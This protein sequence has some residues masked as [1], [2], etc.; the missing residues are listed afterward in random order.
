MKVIDNERENQTFAEPRWL[1]N[2]ETKR[3]MPVV[4]M[5]TLNQ[6]LN[7]TM[8]Y[9][10]ADGRRKVEPIYREATPEEVA[11]HKKQAEKDIASRN[12]QCAEDRIRNAGVVINAADLAK[13]EAP[14]GK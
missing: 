10:Y 11:A 14:K 6:C 12:R 13:P 7:E 2:A 8:E 3:V 9:S 4:N 5:F 1:F